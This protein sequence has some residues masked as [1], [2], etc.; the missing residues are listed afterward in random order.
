MKRIWIGSLLVL[1]A[2]ATHATFAGSTN[3]ALNGSAPREAGI[4]DTSAQ[5]AEAAFLDQSQ[6]LRGQVRAEASFQP[7]YAQLRAQSRAEADFQRRYELLRADGH[8]R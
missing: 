6:R 2:V 1:V 5:S 8:Q 3:V 4:A 7:N